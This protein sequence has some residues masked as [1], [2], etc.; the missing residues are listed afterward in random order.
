M[1]FSLED[2]FFLY[3]I[4][5]FIQVNY[6]GRKA[7]SVRQCGTYLV[8]Q[9]GLQGTLLFIVSFLGQIKEILSPADTGHDNWLSSIHW[10]TVGLTNH[11]FAL[12]KI[13]AN[14]TAL[15]KHSAPVLQTG[16]GEQSPMLN[17]QQDTHNPL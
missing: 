5:F 12:V 11:L 10:D 14:C 9:R 15:Q 4:F 1:I 13:G 16:C 8:V 2:I 6:M 17:V 7:C 3:V